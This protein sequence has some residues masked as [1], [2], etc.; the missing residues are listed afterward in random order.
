M[1]ERERER[2]H[3]AGANGEADHPGHVLRD[4]IGRASPRA[5]GSRSAPSGPGLEAAAV[6]ERA[7]AATGHPLLAAAEVVD[8][9]EVDVSIAGPSATASESEKKGMPRFAFRLPSIG[10]QTT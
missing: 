8:E 2:A 3:D 9:A 10:S 7:F 1:A 6:E 4:E 5:R